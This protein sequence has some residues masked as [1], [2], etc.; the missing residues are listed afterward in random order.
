MRL[1][2]LCYNVHKC[3][4]GL[5]R[6]YDPARTAAVIAA[7]SP[8]LVMLQEVAEDGAWYRGERQVDVLG[9]LL[10]LP[11]RSY[12]VNVRF[13]KRRGS[14]GNAILSRHPIVATENVDLTQPGKK[15][16][17]VLH[18]ELRL[19]MGE[20]HTRTLHAFNMHLGLGEQERRRQLVQFLAAHPFAGLRHKTPIVVAGDFN[21]VYGTLG[22]RLLAP[23][24]FLGPKKPIWT[25]PAYAPVRALDSLYVRGDVEVEELTRVRNKTAAAASDHL[26]LLA[27]LR[28]PG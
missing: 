17:S 27:M 26:P 15:R 11:H 23:N 28:L 3:V 9:D 25:F 21:D 10:G 22:P 19:Q 20:G 24:G 16:R 5:D 6:R 8:D 18:A 14:Y 12:F 13:G 2:V 1:A 7:G 4:G